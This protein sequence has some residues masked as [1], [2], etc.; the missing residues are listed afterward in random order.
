MDK[1]LKTVRSRLLTTGQLFHISF[2][3]A[4]AGLWTPG[5]QAGFD[6]P[7]EHEDSSWAYPEPP[8]AAIAVAPKV[9]DCF[10]GVFPNVAKFFEV[11]KYPHMN[12]YVYRPVFEGDER[13]VTPQVLTKDRWVWDAHVTHEHRIIDPVE[14]ELV[15]EVEIMNCNSSPTMQTHPYGYTGYPKESVGPTTIKYRWL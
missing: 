10:R 13:V 9:E 3:G 2:N 5:T 15:G 14:M 7:G 6:V 12:F 1:V 11:E 4:L 8:M